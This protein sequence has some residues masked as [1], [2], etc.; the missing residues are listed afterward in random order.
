MSVKTKVC[1]KCVL[2]QPVEEYVPDKNEPDGLHAWC[3]KCRTRLGKDLSEWRRQSVV[4]KTAQ[5]TSIGEDLLTILGSPVASTVERLLDALAGLTESTSAG[6]AATLD[7][8][9]TKTQHAPLPHFNPAWAETVQH[10]TDD[11]LWELSETLHSF[12]NRPTDP[13]TWSACDTCGNKRIGSSSYCQTCGTRIL[14]GA[15]RCRLE[16]CPNQGGRRS[17]CPNLTH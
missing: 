17:N 13:R 3:N 6:R 11:Q 14:E 10:Q 15:R 9:K 8:T 4:N 1:S 5:R 16:G 2:E 12:L 7:G